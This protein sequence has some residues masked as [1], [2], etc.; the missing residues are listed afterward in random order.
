MD[1]FDIPSV[2]ISLEQLE[3]NLQCGICLENFKEQEVAKQLGCKHIYHETCISTWLNTHPTCPSCRAH[4]ISGTDS[5]SDEDEIP[6]PLLN[7]SGCIF[8]GI[9]PQ[10]RVSNSFSDNV[11][12]I[13]ELSSVSSEERFSQCSAFDNEQTDLDVDSIESLSVDDIPVGQHTLSISANLHSCFSGVNYLDV[14]IDVSSPDSESEY[15]MEHEDLEDDDMN[16]ADEDS[17]FGEDI[18]HPSNEDDI[19][20]S[21]LLHDDDFDLLSLRS[22]SS[23][24]LSRQG[25][26]QCDDDNNLR[27]DN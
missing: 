17:Y 10:G 8:W 4:V 7:H 21:H 16:F 22:S 2:I 25:A 19:Y 11:S 27:E 24:L 6:L 14:E 18:L 9:T 15:Y 26:N 23:D 12:N 1:T 13:E 20:D 3:S 5:F